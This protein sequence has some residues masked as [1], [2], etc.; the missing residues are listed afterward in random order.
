MNINIKTE[1]LSLAP[2]NTRKNIDDKQMQDLIDSVTKHGI[3][4]PIIVRMK[5]KDDYE[6]VCGSRRFFAATKVKLATV[7]CIVKVLTDTEA[8]EINIV[9]NL[10]REDVGAMDEANGIAELMKS[11]KN[12]TKA[13]AS[14]LGKSESYILNRMK[15]LKLPKVVQDAIASEEISPAHGLVV[16]RLT[17]IGDQKEM[18]KDIKESKMSVRGA[19]NHLSRFGKNISNFKFDTKA[20]VK[21]EYNG[22]KQ[23]DLFDKETNLKGKCLNPECVARKNKQWVL[24]MKAEIVKMGGTILSEK[25][26][27]AKFGDVYGGNQIYDTKGMEKKH[28]EKCMTCPK[29]C[30][31]LSKNQYE[32]NEETIKEICFNSRCLNGTTDDKK[33]P[34]EQAERSEQRNENK[35]AERCRAVLDQTW[36][37][38]AVKNLTPHAINVLTCRQVRSSEGGQWCPKNG[39]AELWKKTDAELA[40]MTQ[41]ALIGSI[42]D[43][44]SI[45]ELAELSVCLKFEA[46]KNLKLTDTYWKAC[47]KAELLKLGKILGVKDLSESGKRGDIEA[48][49]KAA[50]KAGFVPDDIKKFIKKPN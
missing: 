22:T 21:C 3:L 48:K 8:L 30:Y 45:Y 2:F 32:D 19:E 44:Y 24:A 16:A 40:K 41:D 47:S 12:D 1:N 26:Y 43:Q 18:L 49:V 11:N 13:V 15:L 37:E 4:Q 6:I 28:K 29:H 33:D 7:P 50:V 9:E 25:E 46:E 39:V 14:K 36:R 34:E 27:N 42:N 35:T 20:C 17:D 10:Q 5:K 38:F 23:K 31:V